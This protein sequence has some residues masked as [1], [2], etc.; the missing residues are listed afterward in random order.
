M[1]RR[2][3][4]TTT[5]L[6]LVVMLAAALT[7][8]KQLSHAERVAKLRDRYEATLNGFAV[9]E[10]PVAV[11]VETVSPEGEEATAADEAV[12][13]TVAAETGAMDVTDEE[14]EMAEPAEPEMRHDVI[15]DIVVRHDADEPL[16]G[17]TLDV[18]H[19]DASGTEKAHHRIW[20]DTSDLVKGDSL[21]V[22]HTLEDVDYTEGD[23]FY[24]EVRKPVPPSEQGEYAEFS[25][26]G[27]PE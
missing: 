27:S 3:I 18:S 6:A 17:I 25:N 23:G 5:A 1:F 19:A 11:D 10:T 2:T 20:V 22:N 16:P 7:A 9:R 13:E 15:L 14:G 21:Q 24:V 26:G 4:G 12:E 8:C